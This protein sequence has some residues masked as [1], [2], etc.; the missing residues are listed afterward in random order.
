MA[1]IIGTAGSD[2]LMGTSG[3]DF[4][5]TGGGADQIDAG[6]GNDIVRLSGSVPDGNRAFGIIDGGSGHDILDLTQWQGQ[7]YDTDVGGFLG[8]FDRS[9]STGHIGVVGY[10]RGFEEVHLGTGVQSFSAYQVTDDN[11]DTLVGWTI[12]GSE[13]ADVITDSRGHDKIDSGAGNYSIYFMGGSDRVALGDGNDIF[14]MQANNSDG[15]QVT[16]DGGAGVDLVEVSR[17]ALG[18]HMQFDLAAGTGQVGATGFSLTGIENVT[19][20]ALAKAGRTVQLAGDNGANTLTATGDADTVLLGRGGNDGL[21]GIEM[22]RGFTAFGGSGSD[23]IFG[24][25]QGDWLN[26][27]GHYAGDTMPADTADDAGD[28]IDGKGGNDHIFGNSQNAVQGAADGGDFIHG[29]DGGDYVNGNAGADTIFGDA[30]S[31]RLY[32]GADNDTID[33]GAGNDHLNG[34]KGSDT[35]EGGDG[36]DDLLG[37]QGDDRLSG[38]DGF[39]TLTGNAGS[40][41]FFIAAYGH[42]ATSGPDAYRMDIIADFQD[43]QD[44][45]ELYSML[46]TVLH[47]GAAADVAAAAVLANTALSTAGEATVAAVQVGTDTY[48]FYDNFGHGP[49]SAVQ[50]I[51]VTASAIGTSDFVP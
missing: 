46:P 44:K 49:E 8:F 40:D 50:L 14:S 24:S 48:L 23:S 12:V 25:D 30:G 41:T 16:I 19:I 27:G 42:F 32:G 5:D 17:F 39:D 29:G 11:P 22:Q 9:A 51:G 3:K 13:G 38:G 26:G 21:V 47:P 36:N 34:N 45:L 2:T 15:D 18:P 33:G 28:Y 4:I 43:G 31:D 1:T 20:D 35:L 6:A 10:V 37:G 7:L